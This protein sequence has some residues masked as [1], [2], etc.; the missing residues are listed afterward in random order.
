MIRNWLNSNAKMREVATQ[1]NRRC[2]KLQTKNIYF[3]LNF[4]YEII[5]KGLATQ[6]Q[7]EWNE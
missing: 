7:E 6:K 5:Q 2:R 1:L 3:I 4:L